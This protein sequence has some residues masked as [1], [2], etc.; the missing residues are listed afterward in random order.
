MDILKRCHTS[1]HGRKSTT[2]NALRPSW[3]NTFVST[4]STMSYY[5]HSPGL[6]VCR[7]GQAGT[8]KLVLRKLRSS[9][10]LK[11]VKTGKLTTDSRMLSPWN[12]TFPALENDKNVCRKPSHAVGWYESLSELLTFAGNPDSQCIKNRNRH[13]RLTPMLSTS[14]MLPYFRSV[15]W[16][17]SGQYKQNHQNT[18]WCGRLQ[19]ALYYSSPYHKSHKTWSECLCF[20][21]RDLSNSPGR[22]IISLILDLDMRSSIG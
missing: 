10:F 12:E 19:S 3:R 20:F 1:D 9:T 5:D 7:V 8:G 13:R 21:I 2:S 15:S 16:L 6:T 4:L 18:C 17:F 11:A 14:W 22:S